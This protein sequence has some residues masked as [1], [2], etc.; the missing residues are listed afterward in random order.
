MGTLKIYS[1]SKL[2]VYNTVLLTIVTMLYVR[3]QNLSSSNWKCMLCDQHPPISPPSSPWQLSF[4][5]GTPLFCHHFQR[6][7]S[8]DIESRWAGYFFSLQ[9]FEDVIFLSFYKI[10]IINIP[11]CYWLFREWNEG[12]NSWYRIGA[13]DNLFLLLRAE[14]LMCTRRWWYSQEQARSLFRGSLHSCG[15]EREK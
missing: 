5:L 10:E 1:P 4:W 2:E 11:V 14:C 3:S 6:T 8:L 9:Q 7:F 12:N 15:R 13:E